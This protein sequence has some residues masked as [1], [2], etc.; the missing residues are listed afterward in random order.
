MCGCMSCIRGCWWVVFYY[1]CG[2]R[3]ADIPVRARPIFQ[4]RMS[5]LRYENELQKLQSI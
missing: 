5:G 1:L 3:N 2:L 4:T